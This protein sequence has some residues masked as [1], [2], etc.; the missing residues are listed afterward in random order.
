MKQCIFQ[1]TSGLGLSVGLALRG[2]GFV[3]DNFED[4]HLSGLRGLRVGI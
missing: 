3:L 2:L 1:G 4:L